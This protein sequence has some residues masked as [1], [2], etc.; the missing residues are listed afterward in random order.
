MAFNTFFGEKICC[1]NIFDSRNKLYFINVKLK[2]KKTPTIFGQ[3]GN[4]LLWK[5]LHLYMFF[6][7]KLFVNFKPLYFLGTSVVKIHKN[8]D[9]FLEIQQIW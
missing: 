6:Y 5:L 9:I 1:E 7:R 3:L 2:K 8:L 4:L